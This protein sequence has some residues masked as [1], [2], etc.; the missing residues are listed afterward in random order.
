MTDIWTLERDEHGV[1]WA[2]MDMPGRSANVL[3]LAALE[4]FTKVIEAVE[5][6]TP[7]GLVI[8]SKKDAGFMAGADVELLDEMSANEIRAMITD[9]KDLLER[10]EDLDCP[11]VAM[12]HGHCLGGGLE[13]ALACD[14]RVAR[15]DTT[16]GLP[17]VK[18]GLCP[19]LGGTYRLPALIGAADGMGL[20]LAGKTVDAKK[21]VKLGLFDEAVPQRH[22][23]A[24]ARAQ[25]DEEPKKPGRL[26]ELKRDALDTRPARGF[27]ASQMRRKTKEKVRP[28]HYP[29]PFRI[30]DLFE[31][32]GI[33]NA[34]MD[35]ETELFAELSGSVASRNLRRVFLLQEQKKREA[36]LSN[37]DLEIR[38][39]HLIGA[40]AM[41]GE[42]AAWAALKGFEVTVTDVKLDP[43]AEAIGKAKT[44]FRKKS[45]KDRG[46]LRP[47]RNRL[48]PDP[49]GDGVER[50]DLV[51]EA[52]PEKLD[53]K[54]QLFEELEPRMKQSAI[55]ATNTSSLKLKAMASALKRPGRLVG[56]HFFNPVSKMPL[57]EVIRH[58]RTTD[59][60]L[61]QAA[62]FAEAIDKLPVT[63]RDGAGFIVNRAL[64]PYLLEA[65]R[66]MEEEI[67]PELIDAAAEQFGMA[68][69]P[70]E[71]ADHVGLDIALDVAEHLREDYPK[72]I[73]EI[74]AIVKKTLEKRGAGVKDGCGFYEYE[75]GEA[76][77][78]KVSGEDLRD[79][80]LDP[81]CD[82]LILPL[83]NTCAELLHEGI[84]DSEEDVDAGLIFGAGFA[85]FRGGPFGYARY[86]GIESV[87]ADL[88][89]LQSKHGERFAPSEGWA[90]LKG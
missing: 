68:Q 50:A 32:H 8:Y 78:D 57:V 16:A 47:P 44:L 85:P 53:L 14:H 79:G 29:A 40:G 88:E 77:K 48:I 59:R 55:I 19:G 84:A 33:D 20:I 74:P 49:R 35:A 15:D 67:A 12:V 65:A 39:V 70:V 30:I 73:G 13:V 90:I 41:G 9:G 72:E 58:G 62:G 31:E 83:L 23:H 38:R 6:D 36:R 82:R 80:R 76:Q 2:G 7:E 5:A 1:A 71:V 18:L 86:R 25:L 27:L 81:I 52:A 61:T 87:V 54:K 26:D 63:A 51:I 24:A 42:I 45:A 66:M 46:D 43:I 64:T 60:A 28:G 69:G 17:E 89:K 34:L 37:D 75:G 56:L 3:D 21:G 22:L 11:T 4:S 10:I